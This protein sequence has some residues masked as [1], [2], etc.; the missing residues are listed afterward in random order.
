MAGMKAVLFDFYGTLARAETWGPTH[1][2]VLAEHGY[3][4]DE[5]ARAAWRT[6]VFDGQEHV[7]HSLDRARYIAWERSRLARMA[8]A[9]GVG[10]DDIDTLV[11]DLYDATK[12]FTL[13]AY[14]EVEAVLTRLREAGI[15]VVVCSNWDWDLDRA[16]A[17]AGIDRLLD[18][19]VTSA[20]AGA[21]KPHPRIYQTT[22]VAAGVDAADAIFVGDSWDCDVSGP[23]AAG[24]PVALHVWR[25]VDHGH[26]HDRPAPPPLVPG[27][28]RARDLTGVLGLV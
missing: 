24:L 9:C 22:L 6:E 3:D 20:R 4:V 27:A 11:D 7:E 21:R 28:H 19:V 10:P 15:R 26:D 17:T 14:P 12:A 2:Q 13:L 23:L 16:L 25:D 1:E 18:V 8:T 5:A